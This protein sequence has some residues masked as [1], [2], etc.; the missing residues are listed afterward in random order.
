MVLLNHPCMTYDD[1]VAYQK[2]LDDISADN[3]NTNEHSFCQE[4][5][6]VYPALV[7]SLVSFLPNVPKVRYIAHTAITKN[8][9]LKVLGLTTEDIKIEFNMKS[10]LALPELVEDR[11]V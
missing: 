4:Q 10:V 2:R 1:L 5:E 8:R 7:V 9:L 6:T 3:G 11:E